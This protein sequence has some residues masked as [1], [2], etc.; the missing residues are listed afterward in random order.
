LQRSAQPSLAQVG[1]PLSAAGQA[2]P[3]A[4]QFSGSLSRSTQDPLQLRSVPGQ[5]TPQLPAEQT[6]LL[7]QAWSQA[8]QLPGS[9]VVSTHR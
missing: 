7:S 8:P 2:V 3:H 4:L 1:A 9:F 6:S 5:F